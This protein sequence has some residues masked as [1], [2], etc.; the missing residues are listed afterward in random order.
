MK[1]VFN[2][3]MC[4]FGNNGG[5]RTIIKSAAVLAKLGA[6]V[7]LFGPYKYTWDE[8]PKN[9]TIIESGKIPTCD[10]LIATG[11]STVPSTIDFK[12]CKKKFWWVRGHEVWSAPE[13]KL[14]EYYKNIPCIVNSRWLLNFIKKHTG[15]D[16]HLIYQGFDFDIWKNK[17]PFNDRE[18]EIG[19]LYSDRHKTKNHYLLE[20][21]EK[22]Y[23]YKVSLLNRD[24]AS[25]SSEELNNWYNN[26]KIWVSTSVLEGFHNPPVEASLSGCALIANDSVRGGTSDYAIHNTNCV[27]Y[28]CEDGVKDI[29]RLIK[30]YLNNDE[31]AIQYNE[32]ICRD[33][34]GI[35]GSREENMIKMLEILNE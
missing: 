32:R 22:E 10:I 18:I 1:I 20:I 11:Q 14:I 7:V 30:W 15:K 21:L 34:K 26:I 33:I 29:D 17:K 28:N 2:G 6:E 23:G 25:P 12:R 31:I 8:R 24:I 5:S 16:S 27:I 35:I 13:S 19:G 4:G 3:Y 9:V